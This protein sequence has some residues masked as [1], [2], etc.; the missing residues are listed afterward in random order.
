MPPR[1]PVPPG[2]TPRLWQDQALTAFGMAIREGV[3]R[4]I[5]HAATG[6][7]K[8]TL[9]AGLCA[10]AVRGGWPVLVLVHRLNLVDD[11]A[12]RIKRLGEKVGIVQGPRH[13]IRAPIV[14]ASVQ[15]LQGRRLN[16]LGPVNLVITDECHHATASSY[17]NVYAAVRKARKK[18]GKP[19]RFVSLGLTATPFRSDGRGGTLGL[20]EVYDAVVYSHGIVEAIAAGDLV[21]PRGIRVE[22]HVDISACKVTAGGDYDEADLARLTDTPARNR[23]VV[24]KYVEHGQG[25]PALAFCVDVAHSE[26]VAEAFREAGIRA[27]AIHSKLPPGEST[28]LI[29]AYLAGKI[30]VLSSCEMILEGFDAPLA[31]V[32]LR[33]RATM[34]L[35]LARQMLGRGLRTHPG[36]TECIVIDFV[37][38]GVPLAIADDAAD[39]SKANEGTASTAPRLFAPGDMVRHRHSDRSGVGLVVDASQIVARVDWTDPPQGV[40]GHSELALVRPDDP[41]APPPEI[42]ISGASD[43]KLQLL[44]GQSAVGGMGWYQHLGE[45][46]TGGRARDG[47]R[48]VALMRQNTG[49]DWSLWIVRYR[50]SDA[51]ANKA[52]GGRDPIVLQRQAEGI[53]RGWGVSVDL[54]DPRRGEGAT[55]GQLRILGALRAAHG[56]DITMGEA[57]AM[58][59]ALKA[60]AAVRGRIADLRSRH[61]KRRR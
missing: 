8:G 32:L 22:T 41:D 29:S 44:P 53:L 33:I 37:D 6:T 47:A 55:D 15:S 50:G 16:D 60:R 20:G 57:S 26:H 24:E 54:S 51:T 58:I 3:H 42:V 31:A 19:E 21:P 14:V 4:P 18:A 12:N 61:G 28:R 30:Q 10:G 43:Y 49:G 34:S 59:D 11:L 2:Q 39:L 7:G 35:V 38:D 56:A 9:L 5:I 17:Q 25:L 13:Q 40:H 23:L 48:I 46:S 52:A 45:S 27:Q 1:L 36:K